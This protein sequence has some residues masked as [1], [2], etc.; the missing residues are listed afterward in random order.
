MPSIGTAIVSAASIIGGK[1]SGD[2]AKDAR[3]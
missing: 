3:S 2:A 1:L